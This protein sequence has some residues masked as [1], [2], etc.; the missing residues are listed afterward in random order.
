MRIRLHMLQVLW[1]GQEHAT[2][3]LQFVRDGLEGERTGDKSY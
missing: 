1:A 2:Q 3:Q